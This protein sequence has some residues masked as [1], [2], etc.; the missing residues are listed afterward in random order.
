MD[1]GPVVPR[2]QYGTTSA[3]YLYVAKA[4][5]S[6]VLLV[7]AAEPAVQELETTGIVVAQHAVEDRDKCKLERSG[8]SHSLWLFDEHGGAA[9]AVDIDPIED[10]PDGDPRNGR[11]IDFDA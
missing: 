8:G 4:H 3:Q 7:Q 5:D 2:P 10:R 1:L 6:D 11:R 9:G